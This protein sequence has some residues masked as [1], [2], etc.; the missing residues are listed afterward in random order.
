ML[1]LCEEAFY[2]G[3]LRHFSRYNPRDPGVQASNLFPDSLVFNSRGNREL[4]QTRRRRKRERHLK[5]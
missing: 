4:K 1:V 2:S 3:V 5:M